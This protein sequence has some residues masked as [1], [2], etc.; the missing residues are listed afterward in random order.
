M[1]PG[2]GTYNGKVIY[3]MGILSKEGKVRQPARLLWLAAL[4]R[5]TQRRS[6][7][8]AS[9]RAGPPGT[10]RRAWACQ[11]ACT[12]ADAPIICPLTVP[13]LRSCDPVSPSGL[14]RALLPSAPRRLAQMSSILKLDGRWRTRW[15]AVTDGS[16]F[17]WKDEAEFRS[18]K[19]HK[20]YAPSSSRVPS[21]LRLPCVC[22]WLAVAPAVDVS[23]QIALRLRVCVRA[24]VRVC[25]TERREDLQ[26][27]T[28]ILM[29]GN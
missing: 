18:G 6:A 8:H 5:C 22:G 7:L 16:L 29:P 15:V 4:W 1:P 27:N 12:A 24:W 13:L 25:V 2:G 14:T 26:Q 20:G 21:L 11:C 23:D 10:R 19:A 17:Y 3:K 28:D 9:S